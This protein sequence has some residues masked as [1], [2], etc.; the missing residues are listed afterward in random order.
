MTIV[1]ASGS[2]MPIESF[3]AHTPGKPLI[4][5]QIIRPTGL[6]D[7]K[8]TMRPLKT[9]IDETLELCRQRVERGERVLITTLT[10]RTAEDLSDYLRDV[11]LRVRYLHSDIDTI[12]RVE[13]LRALRAGEFDI[14][15]GIN[16]LREGLDLP[17]VSLVCILDADKEGYLRSQ[18][19]LIQTAGRAARHVNG[20]VFLFADE[21]TRSMQA[22][23]DIT[24]YRR[25]RQ[26]AYNEKHGITPK[27]VQRSVQESLHTILRARDVESSVVNEAGGDFSLSETLRELEEE[28]LSASSALEYEKAALLRDQIAELKAGTGLTKIEP[29]RKP[30]TYGKPKRGRR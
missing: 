19:S 12:E 9:Q 1:R 11:G 5:E 4:V 26:L 17:E 16:L 27:S 15:V 20:E 14:L 7:P 22:L 29:K 30:V 8:I 6:L 18:T 13:I 24:E 21:V 23:L 2:A 10:K 25:A 3:D 28:M